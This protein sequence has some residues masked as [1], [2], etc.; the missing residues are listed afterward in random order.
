M[1]EA[2]NL[3]FSVVQS[4]PEEYEN[5]MFKFETPPLHHFGGQL[6]KSWAKTESY[7]QMERSDK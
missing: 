5:L 7:S 1:S 4:S 2:I 3:T 6:L